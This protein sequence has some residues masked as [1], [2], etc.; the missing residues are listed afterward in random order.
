MLVLLVPLVNDLH[1]P[2]LQLLHLKIDFAHEVCE[3]RARH[4]RSPSFGFVF[5]RSKIMEG[6][7]IFGK[8]IL[9]RCKLGRWT[10]IDL[11]S[12][13]VFVLALEGHQLLIML[14]NLGGNPLVLLS[15]TLDIVFSRIPVALKQ[16]DH[17]R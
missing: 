1:H 17:S 3:M 11:V 15:G 5:L 16:I 2:N 9:I 10:H 13:N 6:L 7:F 4:R 12:Q 8:R 14:L